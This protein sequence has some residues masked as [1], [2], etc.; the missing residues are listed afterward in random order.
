[1]KFFIAVLFTLTTSNIV[2]QI[3]ENSY[4]IGVVVGQDLKAKGLTDLDEASI[5]KGIADYLAD[6]K[7]TVS[8]EE[9][10]NN[11]RTLITESAQKVKLANKSV[12]EEFLAENLKKEGVVQTSSG[13]QYKI[14]SSS[15]QEAKPSLSSKVNVHYHG[16]L[17]NGDVFDS[18]VERGEPISF[19]LNGVITGWQ[20]G[21][22]LMSIGDKYRFFIP[23]DLA[24]GERGA[25][26]S[27]GPF[28]ALIFDV[29]LLGIE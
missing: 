24:Y 14:I 29:E 9:A 22:Q 3:D 12:G 4:S 28:S 25:G 13:L 18:S 15:G 1:M 21:L 19:P 16:T 5:A 7:L 2:G 10:T 17:I 20:E 6:N 8:L 26:G 27:I 11:F 23:Y